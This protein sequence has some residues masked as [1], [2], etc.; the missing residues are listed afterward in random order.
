LNWWSGC[1]RPTP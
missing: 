1:C